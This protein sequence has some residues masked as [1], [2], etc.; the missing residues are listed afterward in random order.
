MEDS[1]RPSSDA[2]ADHLC[3]LIHGLWGN[4]SHLNYIVSALREKYGES[5]LQILCP[6]S[7]AGT[8][9]YDGI[10]LGGE[11]VAHE[12]EETIRTSAEQGCK[13]RKLSVVGYSLG[14][15]IARYAIGLLYA[16]GYFDDIEPVNF[17]T[18]ASPHVGVRSPARTSHFWNVLGARCVSTSGRQLFMI[19]SFHDTGKPLLSILATPGSIFMLALAKFR[20]RTLYANAINDLSAVYY[21]TAIS[22]IDPFTQVDDLSISYV[23]GY[24]PVVIDPDRPVR[25]KPKSQSLFDRLTS[26]AYSMISTFS[27][28]LIIVTIVG[29]ASVLFLTNAVYQTILSEKR[30]RL[31]KQGKSGVMY[32]TYRVPL[33]MKGFRNAVE[34]MY[35]TANAAQKPEYISGS[36]PASEERLHDMNGETSKPAQPLPA[37]TTAY[38]ETEPLQ[39]TDNIA[40]RQPSKPTFPTLALT[41]AQFQ[42]IDNLDTVGFRKYPVHIHQAR[43]SHAAIIVR[44]PRESFK[45]GKIVVRH[46]LEEEFRI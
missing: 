1:D 36:T 17:T 35:E 42:I 40:A 38:T 13:I 22:R 4:P 9:T 41:A 25:L 44:S 46:W 5:T 15:L 24:A 7:N 39:N 20:Y 21:T 45:E 29:F 12:V 33:I 2:K 30:I 3:V 11:R 34:D 8:L 26:S 16:K 43:H 31:H 10:E 37:V 18:F 6:K 28:R 32:N 27:F 14:G 19:D 23:D